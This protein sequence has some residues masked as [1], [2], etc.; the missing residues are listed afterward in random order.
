MEEEYLTVEQVSELT[1]LD[2][3][4][5]RRYIRIGRLEADFLGSVFNENY[6]VKRSSLMHDPELKALLRRKASEEGQHPSEETP[7]HDA[8]LVK[9]VDCYKAMLDEIAHYK[10]RAASITASAGGKDKLKSQLARK[11]REAEELER[12]INELRG[13]ILAKEG[14]IRKLGGSDGDKSK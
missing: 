3:Q 14:E 5:I 4:E 9:L 11:S 7:S 2:P 12:E 8:N 1:G 10:L 13:K 6:R